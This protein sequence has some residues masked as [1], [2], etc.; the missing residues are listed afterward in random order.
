M[1]RRIQIGAWAIGFALG[2]GAT[3][4][5]ASAFDW[6]GFYTGVYG[7]AQLGSSS[8]E[9]DG[10]QTTL[11]GIFYMPIPPAVFIIPTLIPG[12]FVDANF[13]SAGSGGLGAEGGLFAGYL[14]QADRIAYGLEASIGGDSGSGAL[15][16]TG[17]SRTLGPDANIVG[18]TTITQTMTGVIQVGPSV[19]ANVRGR[20]GVV[21]GQTLFY[22]TAGLGVKQAT[23]SSTFT[24]T[25]D[26][27]ATTP[28]ATFDGTGPTTSQSVT[29]LGGSIG[30]GAEYAVNDNVTVGGEYRYSY[31]TSGPSQIGTTFGGDPVNGSF[32]LGSHY[33]GLRL[34]WHPS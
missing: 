20:L 19:D 23:V 31:F 34:A 3:A 27:G 22:A 24:S 10:A 13:S 25:T 30:L 2:L 26:F 5:S 12:Q 4:G 7:G 33:V 18:A 6:T 17:P 8:I 28:L 16:M 1:G 29:M 9:A 32:S 11:P 14:W 15:N 21:V